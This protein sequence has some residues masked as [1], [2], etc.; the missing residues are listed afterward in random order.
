M[1]D[2]SLWDLVQR[3]IDDTGATEA[4]IMRRAGLNKGT[5]TAWRAR[6]VPQLPLRKHLLGLAEAL[7]MDYETVLTAV[8]HDAKYLPED[9]ARREQERQDQETR[10]ILEEAYRVADSLATLPRDEAR[11][12]VRKLY[13]D[14][15]I[16]AVVYS[17]IGAI[18]AGPRTTPPRPTP[19]SDPPA[20]PD[21]FDLA[22]DDTPGRDEEAEADDTP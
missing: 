5:F 9:A 21:D 6:G 10:E 8:L 12:R 17:N 16:S 4:S 14:G 11:A 2:M 1:A 22:A 13:D 15:E 3:Y 19:V 20:T 7:K 18:L